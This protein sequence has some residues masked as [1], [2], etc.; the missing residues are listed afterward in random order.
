MGYVRLRERKEV[1][2]ENF[3]KNKKSLDKKMKACY[4][5]VCK[6]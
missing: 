4:N 5:G 6:G 2:K 3:K 1:E